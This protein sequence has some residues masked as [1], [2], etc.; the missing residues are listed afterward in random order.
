LTGVGPRLVVV[1]PLP[2]PL[3]LDRDI[4]ASAFAKEVDPRSL[5]GTRGMHDQRATD[6]FE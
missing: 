1:E 5:R 4:V 6:K 2:L 3:P